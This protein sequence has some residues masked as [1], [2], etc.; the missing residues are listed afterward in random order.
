MNF[1]LRISR[2]FSYIPTDSSD[3]SLKRHLPLCIKSDI[4]FRHSQKMLILVVS[5]LLLLVVAAFWHVARHHHERK[6]SVSHPHQPS[7][8]R[9]FSPFSGE[10]R[11]DKKLKL[12]HVNFKQT[13]D[14]IFNGKI[15]TPLS[16]LSKTPA[17]PTPH[18]LAQFASK[19]YTDYKT[20]E[21]DAQY[22][23]RL[24]LPDGWKLLTTASN[25][26]RTNGYFGAAFWH[27]EHQQVVIAH[28]G[29]EL[30]NFG[31][32]WTDVVGVFLKHHVP[33]MGSAST[34]AQKVMNVLRKI[35][36]ENGAIFQVFFTG[37]SLGGWLA[38]ITTFTTK[39]LK[40]KGNTFLKGDT[41][42]QSYHPHTV[43]FDSPG[44]K[45]M[46][47]QMADKLDVRLHGHSI[48]LEHLDITSYL[49]AP[50]R[51][52]TCNVHVG[53]VYRIF[54]DLS[55]MACWKKYTALYNLDAH[56]MDKIV[57]AFDPDTGNVRKDEKGKLKI[58]VV[59]DWPV[60]D[61]LSGG[62]EY[63]SF[64]DWA[65]HLNNYHTEKAVED[66][67]IKGYY[68]IRYQTRNYDERV[69]SVSIFSKEEC[70]FL[71]DYRRLCQ[72]PELFK[73]KEMFSEM[74]NN[75]AQ[76]EAG[77]K[78]QS[79]E[80]GKQTIRCKDASELQALIPYVKRL[81]QLFPQIKG[82]TKCAL[83]PREIR[84][85]VY[86]IGT[87]HYLKT[88]QQTPPNFMPNDL[89]IYRSGYLCGFI[90]AVAIFLFGTVVAIF[91]KPNAIPLSPLTWF[92]I[93][94]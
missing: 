5:A 75:R 27:P 90:T 76:E 63:E 52:N 89:S 61:G 33:Q 62:K 91:L 60:T 59:V 35:N 8:H 13:I 49:S 57:Q 80:F 2:G 64:F 87:K 92:N 23:T 46:L 77:K 55:E 70:R 73:P 51:I 31:A 44:C 21:T 24:A 7:K 17:F 26:R 28:R 29:T 41:V 78:L 16:Q 9:V 10:L 11:V 18:V 72:L 68:P 82:K 67:L 22:E 74:R 81:L 94:C 79:F 42:P 43:V 39:Y 71:R 4:T 84:N 65:K 53:T 30:K 50:N 37:H 66:S 47:S 85:N 69:T 88:F 83:S 20:G 45:D 25:S 86:Q 14:D 38:Q 34:F 19:V 54:T 40:I 1:T 58:Q 56:S 36:K 48:D 15:V 3:T 6:N 12:S 32:L 93:P